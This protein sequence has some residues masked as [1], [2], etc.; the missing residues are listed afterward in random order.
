M[1]ANN[2][3]ETIVAIWKLLVLIVQIPIFIIGCIAQPFFL[4][5]HLQDE[6][7]RI[8]R[9]VSFARRLGLTLDPDIRRGMKRKYRFLRNVDGRGQYALNIMTGKYKGH[10]VT[11]FDYHTR[12]ISGDAWGFGD[13]DFELHEFSEKFNVRGKGKKFAYDFCNVQMMEHLL[14]QPVLH[15]PIDLTKMRWPLESIVS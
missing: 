8:A 13:I 3:F 2:A 5:W 9:M 12:T 4:Y 14:D 10:E 7:E 11:V 6:K 15:L 1:S